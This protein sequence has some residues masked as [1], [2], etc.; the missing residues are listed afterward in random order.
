MCESLNKNAKKT[1]LIRLHENPKK[2]LRKSPKMKNV[3]DVMNNAESSIHH[4]SSSLPPKHPS[5]SQDLAM[6]LPS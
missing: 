5:L 2:R 4:K 6:K 3:R 1:P